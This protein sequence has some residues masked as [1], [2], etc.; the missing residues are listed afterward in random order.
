MGGWRPASRGEKARK[1]IAGKKEKE[2]KEERVGKEMEQTVR[3]ETE[4]GT[5]IG[6][7]VPSA[8]K[9]TKVE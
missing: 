2:Q 7:G 1:R 6:S 9:Y 4:G 3:V 8:K 5:D